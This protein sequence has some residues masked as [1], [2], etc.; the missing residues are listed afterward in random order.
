M[1]IIDKIG[2]ELRKHIDPVYR[3]GSQRF[4]KHQIQSLGVQTP[5]VRAIARQF[6]KTLEDKPKKEIFTLA[7][8][9]LQKSEEEYAAI[10]FS[11][12]RARQKEFT[13]ADFVF[14]KRVVGRYVTNWARC[15]DFCTHSMGTLLQMYPELVP[16]IKIW[17]RSKNLWM[18]RAAAVS[19]IY[20]ARKGK[21]LKDIF[22]IADALL[23]DKEDMVQKGY[24]WM[25]KDASLT[26]PGKVYKFVMDRRREMPRTALRYAIERYPREMKREA[27]K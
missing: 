2:R 8:E 16:K 20:P 12:I 10:A 21:Y 24:G 1:R 5:I 22:E 9:L 17:T 19:F 11:F 6:Y 15:D 27:M 7:E 14:F 13:A 18:R 26:E 3:E 4:F 23:L 25:L